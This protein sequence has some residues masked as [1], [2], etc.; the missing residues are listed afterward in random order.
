[1][2]FFIQHVVRYAL[3]HKILAL[4]N[5][6]SVALG[7]SAFLAVQ[8]ANRSA[9][10][11]FRAGIDVVAGRANLEV[12]GTLDDSLFPKLQELAGVTAATPMV[13][14]VVT[15]PEWPG[16]YLHVLGIDPFTNSNF[17]SFKFSKSAKEAFDADAWFGNPRSLAIS[18]AFADS[19]QLKRGDSIQ[20][21]FGERKIGLVVSSVLE[22]KDGDSHYAAMDIGWAQE[23]FGWQGKLTGVLFRISDP[24]N[25]EPVEKRIRTLVPPDALVQEPGARS[26]QVEQMLSGFELNLT[27]LSMISLLVGVFLI[28]NTVTASVV[29]RR[30]EIGILRALGASRAKV[31]C[32]FLGEAAL[33]GMIGSVVGCVG[34]VLMSN[35]L[36]RTVST[37][38]T[39]LYVLTSIDH[40][41][42]P[43]WQIPVV[44][45]VGMGSV[46]VG[47]YIPANGGA[48][49]P[50]LHALD[51]GVLIER[52]E[53]PR[54]IWLVLSG[55]CLMAAFGASVLALCGYAIWGFS[56]AFFTLIGF[57][58]LSPFMTHQFGAGAGRFFRSLL[59]PRLAARN[60]V[61][62]LYRHAIT[63]AA[64]GSAL[65]MLVSVSVMIY[66]FRKTVDRWLTRRLV[67]DLFVAPAANEIVGFENWIPEDLM[68]FLRSRPEVEMID[69]FRYLTLSVNGA[70]TFVGVITG[71][72]R[73][74]PDFIG[75]K[76]AEK[77]EA[78]RAPDT[79]I[80]SESLSRRLK[81][82]RGET[83]TIA[84]PSG[85]RPFKVAGVF[86]DY[87]RDTGVMLMQ[88][89]NFEKFW[90]DSRVNSVAL[91]LQPGTNVE[92]MIQHIRSGYGNA[93][94]YSLYS[95]RALRDAVVEVFNQTFA[96]TQVLRI[97]AVLVAVIGIALNFTV[98]VKERER[99]IG[100]LRAVG[101]SRRQARELIIW[102]SILIG[103]MAVL[104]GVISGIALSV[105]LTEVINKAFFGWTIPLQI[106]WDQLLW[107][108]VWLLPVAVLASLLPANQASRR[109]IVDAVRMDA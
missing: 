19:H 96:V 6:L 46:L 47:A 56:A 21:K 11:A 45:T 54:V 8:I 40:F 34:G 87:S 9:N 27:A 65:A 51:M 63:V 103:A 13:E 108:P 35:F 60:L 90:P 93:Q 14:R 44:L 25:H 49:L 50:P 67:A 106:P 85:P 26:A 89:P 16:E 70:P 82:N 109:N 38:V 42:F 12:R 95:N 100:T 58:C 55:G 23:L 64:L 31:R 18:K 97:M 92:E 1:M 62:S 3:R 88:R 48:N 33:Y 107:I 81:V 68:K 37:T 53:K 78:F 91:Y 75:G 32:L 66:S 52:S 43:F 30:S 4:T 71:S 83:V 59:L 69:T 76:N 77:Y 57:C 84:T 10:A 17:E 24:N 20:V 29:R 104:L 73:N 41:Y 105:V 74:I 80:I 36:V 99:E 98:L 61:R 72:G 39:N 5:I 101:V 2:R 15:L 102:E 86:Y 79:A 7:V 94:D 28:Y 22:A